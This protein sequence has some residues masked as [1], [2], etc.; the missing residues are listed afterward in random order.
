VKEHN[1]ILEQ[2]GLL[3]Q[4]SFALYCSAAPFW[5]PQ[6]SRMKA[7]SVSQGAS[8]A[9]KKRAKKKQKQQLP[10]DAVVV[11]Q[12]AQP[13]LKKKPRR[14]PP[15]EKLRP[16]QS[17]TKVDKTSAKKA[18]SPDSLQE[19]KEL[20][21]VHSLLSFLQPE[22][23]SIP[24]ALQ[25][26][27]QALT[28][29]QR[30]R[31]SLSFLLEPAQISVEEFYQTYWEKKPL[32][33]QASSSA[34]RHRLD[35]LL[36]L[37]SIRQILHNH[38]MAYG[39]DLNVT[40]YTMNPATGIL[41]RLTLDRLPSDEKGEDENQEDDD[42]QAVYIIADP[43]EVWKNYRQGCTVRLLCPHQHA[44]AIQTLLSLLEVEMGCMTGANAY[45]T[46][47]E[48]SQGFAPHYDDIEAFCLQLQGRKRWK[49]Y[50]PLPAQKLPR[51]SS[52]DFT[53]EDLKETE[54]VLDV[55]LSPGDMLYMPRGWIHEACT[56]DGPS[57][58]KKD[59][60]HSLHLTVS[61]MQ[62]WAWVDLLE[63]LLPEALSAAAD[64]EAST[65]LREGLPRNFLDYMG[66]IHDDSRE[67]DVLN[68]VRKKEEETAGATKEE[69][70][71]AQE[72]F[73]TEAK[74]RIMR[75]AKEAMNIIDDACDQLGKQFVGSCQPPALT[76][77]ERQSTSLGQ[78]RAVKILPDMMVRL[79]RP[80]IA[81]LVLED[82]MAVLYHCMDN[83]RAYHGK[84]LSPVEFEMDDAPSI[85]QVLKTLEPHWICVSDLF[86]DTME[87]K[88]GVVQALYDE[89]ILSLR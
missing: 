40:K 38:P 87:D 85:E 32:L 34:H 81:R 48:A 8:R 57:S 19:P 25:P 39:K 12:Q 52:P 46:P 84:P 47:P 49:V 29:K 43:G 83:S 80:G 75:V 7:V 74:N 65:A 59:D 36:S 6:R 61:A 26:I 9:A 20:P 62:Q 33:I 14:D 86:H 18:S 4:L 51:T 28:S 37:E 88:I 42:H 5:F 64:S 55:V 50:S 82:D 23:P 41:R 24:E 1:E 77:K 35:G 70:L 66:V 10:S 15:A 56:L 17:V 89:G 67:S 11:D 21:P 63:V 2:G 13:S 71:A 72:H 79:L 45:L 76:P 16:K 54:A 53:T 68:M 30:A 27:F 31:A 78:A 60:G 58:K 44:D 73:R 69:V 22:D 3:V